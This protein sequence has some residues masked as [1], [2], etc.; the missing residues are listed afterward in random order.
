MKP[1]TCVTKKDIHN[2][3][4]KSYK[5]VGGWSLVDAVIFERDPAESRTDLDG[6]QTCSTEHCRFRFDRC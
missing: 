2:T 5:S 1:K 4:D 6:G 3:S